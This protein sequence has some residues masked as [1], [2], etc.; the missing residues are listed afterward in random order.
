MDR[1]NGT[2]RGRTLVVAAALFVAAGG[3]AFRAWRERAPII[4]PHQRRDDGTDE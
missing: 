4:G 3:A 2:I 1:A